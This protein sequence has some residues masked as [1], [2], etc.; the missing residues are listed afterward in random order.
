MRNR[1]AKVKA[2]NPIA[3]FNDTRRTVLSGFMKDSAEARKWLEGYRD[4]HVLD[5]RGYAGLKAELE[6][7]ERY[8][9]EFGLVPALDIG[10]STD[11]SGTQDGMSWSFDVTTNINFK[12]LAKYEPMQIRGRRYTIAVSGGKDFE[13][14]DINFPFCEDCKTGRVMPTAMLLDDNFCDD[15]ESN[16]SNDQL[17]VTICSGCQRTEV[18]DRLTTPFLYGFDHWYQTLNEARAE[19]EDLGQPPIDIDQEILEYSTSALRYL[20]NQWGVYLVAI[21]GK[22]YKI[23]NPSDADGYWTYQLTHIAPLAEGYLQNEYDWDI[24]VEAL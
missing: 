19:A 11:F 12:N 2:R 17:L 23:T 24:G 9:R 21:G 14:I 3:I 15:G 22:D 5:A 16:W 7:F 13:L 1:I 18:V 10:D 8:E 6:F 4:R 20:R